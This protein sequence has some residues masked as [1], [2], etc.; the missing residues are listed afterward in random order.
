MLFCHWSLVAGDWPTARFPIGHCLLVTVRRSLPIDDVFAVANEPVA[1]ATFFHETTQ[2]GFDHALS[3]FHLVV[4]TCSALSDSRT[5]N[6]RFHDLCIIGVRWFLCVLAY[7]A[8]LFSRK[9]DRFLFA[10]FAFFA[11]SH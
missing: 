10:V 7:R 4:R 5:N 6:R 3:S 8:T 11:L 9:N 1:S 2:A